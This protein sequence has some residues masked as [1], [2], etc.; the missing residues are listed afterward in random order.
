MRIH[1][2][3]DQRL[4]IQADASELFTMLTLAEK[5][6]DNLMEANTKMAF[7]HN[8]LKRENDALR[9]ELDKLRAKLK[10]YGLDPEIKVEVK[11]Q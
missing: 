10:R 4:P 9:K 5:E 7:E 11:I 2:T 1:R 6:L 3:P 8:K